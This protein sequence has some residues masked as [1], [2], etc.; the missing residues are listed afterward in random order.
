M[1]TTAIA[2]AEGLRKTFGQHVALAGIDFELRPGEILGLL[3]P[4]GAGKTTTLKLMLGMLQ[5]TAGRCEV[6]GFDCT[7]SSIEVKRHIGYSP[8]E[9]AFYNFL[10]GRETLDFAIAMRAVDRSTAW[11]EID[12]LVE[13]LDAAE[14]L[15]VLTSTYSHGMKKKLALLLALAHGPSVLLLDEPT[16]GLDPPTALAIRAILQAKASAG[17][18]VIVSTHLLDM[19]DRMCHR[20]VVVAQGHIIAEGTP[21]DVRSRA[22][23]APEASLEEAFMRLVTR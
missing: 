8:D 23:V 16:N 19:A 1:T 2:K 18:A 4:I 13:Q 15:D 3:G 20:V 7:R 5:P 11:A 9:P 14:L 12:A 17:A 6:L 10:T 22:G 21:A